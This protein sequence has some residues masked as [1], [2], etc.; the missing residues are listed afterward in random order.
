MTPQHPDLTRLREVLEIYGADRSRWPAADRLALAGIIADTEAAR[1]L[2]AEYQSLDRLLDA[3]ARREE[4]AALA[5][6]ERIFAAAERN[7][8]HR[9]EPTSSA[10][11][12]PPPAIRRAP[13]RSRF[14]M[15]AIAAA[16]LFI[17]SIGLVAGLSGIVAPDSQEI[18]SMDDTIDI[19]D[20]LLDEDVI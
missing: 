5:L 17:F 8:A 3:A 9:H 1:L 6:T 7:R 4:V 15:A 19:D 11:S 20:P 2:L 16:I 18:A 13:I 12:L 14:E 10:T